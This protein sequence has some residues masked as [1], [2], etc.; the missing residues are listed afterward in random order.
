VPFGPHRLSFA[1]VLAAM[2][3]ADGV[4]DD[5]ERNR[6]KV[7]LNHFALDPGERREVEALLAHPVSFEQAL[8]LTKEFAGRLA[9]PGARRKLLGE[10]ETLLGHEDARSDREH[11]LLAHVRAILAQHTV[12]DGLAEKLRGLFGRTLFAGRTPESDSAGADHRTRLRDALVAAL[13]EAKTRDTDR[14][15]RVAA[16]YNRITS[17]EE[18]LG[19]LEALFAAAAAD[20]LIS[21][22]QA[23][24]IRKI[25]DLLWISNPEYLAVR[26]H[27][28]DRIAT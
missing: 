1:K 17:M 15:Q 2:A 3:W 21:R 18:R 4:V 27:Y 13:D 26:H 8:E 7:L 5:D 12:V 9:P 6:V 19:T 14:L 23:E 28:R 25:A 16:E 20:G 24:R 10:I 22:E 11:E